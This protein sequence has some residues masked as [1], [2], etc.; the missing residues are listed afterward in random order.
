M[1]Y[2]A[3]A[4]FPACAVTKLQ[5]RGSTRQNKQGKPPTSLVGQ[6]HDAQRAAS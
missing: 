2:G 6:Q 1:R 4:G 5:A 3:K